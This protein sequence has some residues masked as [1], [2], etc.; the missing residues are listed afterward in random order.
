MQGLVQGVF[1]RR[2]ER[3]VHCS[4]SSLECPL[5]TL[6]S[7]SRVRT[8]VRDR[9]AERVTELDRVRSVASAVEIQLR[10]AM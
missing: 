5:A 4:L 2:E 3:Q 9:D 1:P 6:A 8:A 10:L 7:E